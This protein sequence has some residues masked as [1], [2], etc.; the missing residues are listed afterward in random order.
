MMNESWTLHVNPLH[1]Y[2]LLLD[3]CVGTRKRFHRLNAAHPDCREEHT[4]SMREVFRTA[5]GECDRGTTLEDYRRALLHHLGSRSIHSPESNDVARKASEA[6]SLILDA[7]PLLDSEDIEISTDRL[8]SKDP[9]IKIPEYEKNTLRNRQQRL[10]DLETSLLYEQYPSIRESLNLLTNALQEPISSDIHARGRLV[11][12]TVDYATGAERLTYGILTSWAKEN[13]DMPLVAAGNDGESLYPPETGPCC[14]IGGLDTG[15]FPPYDP[16][17][18]FHYSPDDIRGWVINHRD[19]WGARSHAVKL[20]KKM[21]GQNIGSTHQLP[22]SVYEEMVDLHTYV[23]NSCSRYLPLEIHPELP[24]SEIYQHGVENTYGK[25]K[26]FLNRVIASDTYKNFDHRCYLLACLLLKLSDNIRR[27]MSYAEIKLS[28]EPDTVHGLTKMTKLRGAISEKLAELPA[29]CPWPLAIT[30]EE[31]IAE[32]TKAIDNTTHL[33]SLRTAVRSPNLNNLS[34]L[35]ASRDAV[36]P[37]QEHYDRLRGWAELMSRPTPLA[38]PNRETV[39]E[40]LE[41]PPT[42]KDNTY[43]TLKT[44]AANELKGKQRSI[45]EALCVQGGVIKLADL[46]IELDWDDPAKGFDNAKRSLNKRLKKMSWELCRHD[47]EARLRRPP[48]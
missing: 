25:F 23:K 45:I 6:L 34:R 37:V 14:T 1:R 41:A 10:K 42:L 11:E 47:G 27:F 20:V 40:Y 3:I 43:E 32:V 21:P 31:L 30:R 33:A 16:N 26:V 7:S 48:G 5:M 13:S 46:G 9:A 12:V 2:I 38:S 17:D 24:S 8:W 18:S 22:E 28:H 39:S 44:F 29:D 36:A 35:N 19:A 15:R 4:A